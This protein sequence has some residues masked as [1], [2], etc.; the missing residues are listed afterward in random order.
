MSKGLIGSGLISGAP[1]AR[2]E[3]KHRSSIQPGDT[4]I[5]WGP[6]EGPPETLHTSQHC[7]IDGFKGVLY[8]GSHYAE[9]RQ[10]LGQPR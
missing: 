5:I 6:I 10:S 7:R 3:K 4:R 8:L 9:L 1:N 2:L